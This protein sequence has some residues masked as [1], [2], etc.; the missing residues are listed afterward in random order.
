LYA[1]EPKQPRGPTLTLSGHGRPVS[2]VAVSPNGTRIASGG[3]DD[4]LRLWDAATGKE[5][6]AVRA[7]GVLTANG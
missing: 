1:G 6:K 2:A 7:G 4:M 3:A 5:L